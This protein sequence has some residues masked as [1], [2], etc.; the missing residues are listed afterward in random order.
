M[1]RHTFQALVA[2]ALTAATVWAF[3]VPLAWWV[4]GACVALVLFVHPTR[5]GRRDRS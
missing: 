4:P 1:L 5:I 3:S 2:G